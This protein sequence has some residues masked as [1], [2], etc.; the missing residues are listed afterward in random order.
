MCF[1]IGRVG[2]ARLIVGICRQAIE[3]PIEDLLCVP[4]RPFVENRLPRSKTL[5]KITPR[6]ACLRDVDDRV[7]E[8]T[9]WQGCGPTSPATFGRKER[10]EA[11]PFGIRELVAMH[12]QLGSK[13]G[14]RGKT[15]FTNSTLHA[16]RQNAPRRTRTRTRTIWLSNYWSLAISRLSIADTRR[17]RCF[18]SSVSAREA[19]SNTRRRSAAAATS[20]HS[21]RLST[22][23]CRFSPA[24]RRLAPSASKRTVFA[25]ARNR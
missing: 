11:S 16:Q 22:K 8:L 24:P 18:S 6:T 5:G 25:A 13:T 19:M 12:H 9:I 14:S 21:P 7:H 20:A 23:R 4:S 1:R 2:D 3:Y 15:P 10:L 17:A